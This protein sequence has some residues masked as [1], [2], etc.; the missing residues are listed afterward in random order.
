VWRVPKLTRLSIVWRSCVWLTGATI[1]R[2]LAST[3]GGGAAPI[4][5]RL[6]QATNLR[7][8]TLPLAARLAPFAHPF[9][10]ARVALDRGESRSNA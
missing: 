9:T 7:I 3:E 10:F 5:T 2:N 4:K 8:T 6:Q 1:A